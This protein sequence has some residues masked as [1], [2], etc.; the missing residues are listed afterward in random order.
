MMRTWVSARTCW[1]SR[2]SPSKPLDRKGWCGRMS[3]GRRPVAGPCPCPASG[4]RCWGAR[5]HVP[6]VGEQPVIFPSTAGKLRD[7][8]NF[9]KEWRRAGE[10]LGHSK[11][12]ITQDPYMSRGRVHT[13]VAELLERTVKNVE[14]TST[15]SGRGEK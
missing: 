5:R 8:N 6:Y 2:A 10:E 4:W 15:G 13:Q 7:P 14:S 1:A 9:G 3:P 12:S 11:V